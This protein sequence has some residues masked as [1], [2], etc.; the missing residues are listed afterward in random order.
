MCICLED[1]ERA[2][3]KIDGRRV[4][5]LIPVF[6]PFC[7]QALRRQTDTS[8]VRPSILRLPGVIFL[9]S[10]RY[11]RKALFDDVPVC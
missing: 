3:V 1:L 6:K 4:N 9:T 11:E 7:K 2:V 10:V 5:A 8:A